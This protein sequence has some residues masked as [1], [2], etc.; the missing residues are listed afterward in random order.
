GWE[1]VLDTNV[2]VRSCVQSAVGML[3]DQTEAG[4][5]STKRVEILLMLL[6]DNESLQAEFIKALKKRLHSLLMAHD[7]NTISGKSW[8]SKEALNIDA[9]QEGGTFRHALWRRVQAV[10]TPFLAQLVSIIDRD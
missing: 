1:N 8:V 7:Q 2:L 5:R 3:R 10:V 4:T 6:D 9:L